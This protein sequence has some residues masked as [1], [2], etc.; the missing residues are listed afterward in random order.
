MLGWQMHGGCGQW[1]IFAVYTTVD[2]ARG[3]SRVFLE[4]HVVLLTLDMLPIYIAWWFWN[5][6]ALLPGLCG[7]WGHDA[8][9]CNIFMRRNFCDFRVFDIAQ[10]INENKNLTIICT[11]TTLTR[12]WLFVFHWHMFV[13]T[14]YTPHTYIS[15]FWL[16]KMWSHD[17][18][19]FYYFLI[20]LTNL[21]KIL[22]PGS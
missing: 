14:Y 15:V 16:A 17:M 11:S 8:K 18:C 22:F 10:E 6:H 1:N 3:W 2:I 4:S 20:V 9:Y 7:G 12:F 19:R 13:K 21:G 5:W